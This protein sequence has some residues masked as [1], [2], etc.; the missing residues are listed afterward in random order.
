MEYFAYLEKLGQ[1]QDQEHELCSSD[2]LGFAR[3]ISA[4]SSPC[5]GRHI[6][7]PLSTYGKTYVPAC[8]GIELGRGGVLSPAPPI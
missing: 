5:Q 7:Q 1:V 2:F 6:V 4:H 8:V 3:C